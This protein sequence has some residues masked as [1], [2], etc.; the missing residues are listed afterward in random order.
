[1]NDDINNNIT[2]TPETSD[3]TDAHAVKPAKKQ[4]RK[5]YMARYYDENKEE[6]AERRK[7]AR[8]VRRDEINAAERDNYHNDPAAREQRLKI[9][10][11]GR[12]TYKERIAADPEAQKQHEERLKNR[13][14]RHIERLATDP[15]YRRQRDEFTKALRE[16]RQKEKEGDDEP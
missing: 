4:D 2:D 8:I 6:I 7:A 9:N 15:E 13:R 11:K 5:E 1:L 12:K 10:A 14:Q 16:K 3:T